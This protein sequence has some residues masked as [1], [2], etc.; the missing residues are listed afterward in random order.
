MQTDPPAP[1]RLLECEGSDAGPIENMHDVFS[2][3][4]RRAILYYLQETEGPATVQALLRKLIEW[5]RGLVTPP[6]RDSVLVESIRT[7]IYRSHV[8]EMAKA[9][10]IEY[11]PVE[12]TI[13]IPD[14]IEFA[15]APPWDDQWEPRARGDPDT[16]HVKPRRHV[17]QTGG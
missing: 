5:D 17:P 14:R 16:P 12:D 11:D 4:C 1:A 13:W 9:D 8:L 10:I 15:I 6:N 3:R 7:S 2:N